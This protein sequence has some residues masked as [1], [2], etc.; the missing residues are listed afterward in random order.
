MTTVPT[1]GIHPT[2]AHPDDAGADLRALHNAWVRPG[3][4]TTIRTGT[5]LAIPDGHF[6]LVAGRSGLGIKH[7]ITLVNGIGVIDAGYRGEIQVGLINHGRNPYQITA[8][9]R[10]AQ[11]IIVPFITAA[12]TAVDDLE[13]TAR[14]TGG[15]GSTGSAA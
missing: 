14:G 13:H 1:K 9:E 10:I 2:Y 3:Q 12:F 4:F 11:L 7:G 5:S 15:L 8:G 6:G